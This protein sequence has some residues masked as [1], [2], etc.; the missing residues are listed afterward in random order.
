[1]LT[2]F[3]L[4]FSASTDTRG[5]VEH[6]TTDTYYGSGPGLMQNMIIESSPMNS[7]FI[8]IAFIYF[9]FIQKIPH[10]WSVVNNHDQ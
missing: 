10:I 4:H 6:R 2:S 9:N 7:K 3:L 1:M 8:V 5:T